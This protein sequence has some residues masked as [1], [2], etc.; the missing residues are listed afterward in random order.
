M[1]SDRKLK[2]SRRF[3]FLKM[4]DLRDSKPSDTHAFLHS[5]ADARI[6]TEVMTSDR[7]IKASREGSK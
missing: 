7:K 4:K 5:N 3:H 1:T 6:F 2:A